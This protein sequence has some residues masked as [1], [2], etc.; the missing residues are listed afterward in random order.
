MKKPVLT[1]AVPVYNEIGYLPKVLESIAAQTGENNRD[2]FEVLISDNKSTD[3]TTGYLKTCPLQSNFRVNFND[4]NIGADANFDLLVSEAR[5]DHVWLLGGQDYLKDGSIDL[6]ISKIKTINPDLLLLNFAISTEE[7]GKESINVAYDEVDREIFK[8]SYK[9]FISTGGP[10]LAMSSNVFRK[11]IYLDGLSRGR[12]S[13]NWPHIESLYSG[14]FKRSESDRSGRTYALV[15]TPV[16][17]LFREKDGWWTTDL[18]L[19]N[20]LNLIEI[21]NKKI[22]NPFLKYRI[23]HRRCGFALKNSVLLN[24]ANGEQIQFSDLTR[25]IRMSWPIPH[26]WLIA[27]PSLIKSLRIWK[28]YQD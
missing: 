21:G 27:F 22:S 10:G 1:I 5:A 14:L 19:Q 12:H 9:F 8:S 13:K 7:G 16:F 24:L 3:G 11:Q 18:V 6:I 15:K 25:I 20:Y 28:R 2:L 23:R 17:T 26:F 4:K